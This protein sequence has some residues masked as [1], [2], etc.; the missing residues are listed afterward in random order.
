MILSGKKN[1]Q[2]LSNHSVSIL[3]TL[4]S[5]YNPK[6]IS[7]IYCDLT[8]LHG[9]K[10]SGLT[11]ESQ[12][13]YPPAFSFECFPART[14]TGKKKLLDTSHQL[15]K[16]NPC[17]FSVTYGA[18]GST[19]ERTLATVDAINVATSIEVVPH[20][21]GI[22]A[23]QDEITSQLEHYKARGIRHIVVLRGDTPS[24]LR[25]FGD[26]NYAND[27]I[28]FIRKQYGDYFF[29]EVAAY[30]ETHPLAT[31]AQTDLISLQQKF[32]SGADAALTQYFY[33][34]DAFF[35]FIDACEKRG[36]DQP[37]VPG[38]MPI[39]HYHPLARFSAMCGAEIPRWIRLR[40]EEYGDD[41]VSLADFGEEVVTR[42]C[43]QLLAGGAAGL[44]FY[45][46]NQASPTLAIWNNLN[47]SSNKSLRSRR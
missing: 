36:I 3:T 25:D 40:L 27:L 5:T 41:L 33:N 46:M 42:L 30:P 14:E 31:S 11:M 1:N 12:K 9:K 22:G 39:T 23:S 28:R 44:H 17:F 19:R 35:R 16:V 21:A 4:N 47:I 13:I 2:H 29:I 26:F 15:A 34:P 43:E 20:I 45:T 38:I 10:G 37:I 8:L 24:G 18:G 32:E 7:W 6:L